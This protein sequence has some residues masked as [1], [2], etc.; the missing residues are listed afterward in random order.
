[1][2]QQ[3]LAEQAQIEA[4]DT[5]DFDSF[6]TAYGQRTSSEVCCENSACQYATRRLR[7]KRTPTKLNQLT[8]SLASVGLNFA[9]ST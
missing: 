5:G 4:A 7:L 8:A 6:I 1:M 2:A 3:S 9:V